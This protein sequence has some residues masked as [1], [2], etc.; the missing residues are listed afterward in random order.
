VLT[1]EDKR[2]VLRHDDRL[3]EWTLLARWSLDT[4]YNDKIHTN[5]VRF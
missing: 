1:T 5:I 4:V 2:Y 3:D